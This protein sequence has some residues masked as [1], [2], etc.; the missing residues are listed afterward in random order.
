MDENL[1][2]E[3]ERRFPPD[4]IVPDPFGETG[5]AH[6]DPYGDDERAREAF[7]AGAEWAVAHPAEHLTQ[8]GLVHYLVKTLHGEWWVT[9]Q[10]AGQPWVGRPLS[11]FLEVE[12]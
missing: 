6:T 11:Y 10:K 1:H 12:K 3:A 5:E 7:I 2:A 4:K 9:T 8:D